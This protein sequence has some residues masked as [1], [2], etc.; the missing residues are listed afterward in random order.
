MYCRFVIQ[1]TH[2]SHAHIHRTEEVRRAKVSML[3][4]QI[5]EMENK[6]QHIDLDGFV[7]NSLTTYAA[8]VSTV[9]KM[10]RSSDPY[11]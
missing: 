4:E 5:N 3:E 6:L 1:V 10:K 2:R 8:A 11:M 7:T 9:L